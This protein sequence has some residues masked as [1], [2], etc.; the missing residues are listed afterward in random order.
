MNCYKCNHPNLHGSNFC[1]KCG[2]DLKAPPPPK[3]VPVRPYGGYKS[4]PS[5]GYSPP[6]SGYSAPRRAP[7]PRPTPAPKPAPAGSGYSPPS[8]PVQP[9]PS[10]AAPPQPSRSTP[11]PRK[12]KQRTRSP[13]VSAEAQAPAPTQPTAPTPKREP[14]PFGRLTG[15]NGIEF[16]L[17]YD[18][19][20]VGRA[21]PGEGINPQVD[22][23]AA[24]TSGTVSRKHARIG[25]DDASIFLED[26]GSSN[27]TRH[28]GQSLR[29]GMQAPLSDGDQIIFGDI[30]FT[31]HL[32]SSG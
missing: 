24:D 9:P 13:F 7:A 1:E 11:P 8:P 15:P 29:S 14:L 12:E 27:G 22:L 10:P 16:A 23:T 6:S 4:P 5:S 28:N 20:L 19:N 26:L 30:I 32:I 25:K 2:A 21:S 17:R 31:F 3:V 18:R